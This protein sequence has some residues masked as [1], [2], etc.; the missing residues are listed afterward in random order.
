VTTAGVNDNPSLSGAA[1]TAAV[2]DRIRVFSDGYTRNPIIDHVLV[3]KPDVL[4][5][6]FG[7]R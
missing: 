1:N 4:K 7:V 6:A 2:F 5:M 3:Q